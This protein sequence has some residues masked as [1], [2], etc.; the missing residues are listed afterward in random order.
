VNRE[1]LYTALSRGRGHNHLYV[2]DSDRRALDRHARELTP[3]AYQRLQSAIVR[4]GAQ[5]RAVD[6]ENDGLVPLAVLRAE[7]DRLQQALARRPYNPTSDLRRL[8]DERRDAQRRLAHA[9]LDRARVQ[10]ELHEMPLFVRLHRRQH[11]AVLEHD[12]NHL[13][14]E[15]ERQTGRLHQLH[16]QRND[17]RPAEKAWRAWHAEHKPNLDRLATLRIRVSLTENLRPALA[18]VEQ[19]PA[20]TFEAPPEPGGMDLSA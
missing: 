14:R 12:L 17:L 10:H 20:P 1:Q 7:R 5:Q 2:D 4:S 18:Q 11:R 15:I 16:R 3:T 19:A 8:A 9:G 13:D 6:H